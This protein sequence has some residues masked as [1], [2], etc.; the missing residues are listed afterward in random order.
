MLGRKQRL[1]SLAINFDYTAPSKNQLLPY[2]PQAKTCCVD[3]DLR[4][5]QTAYKVPTCLVEKHTELY[6]HRDG[7]YNA[8]SS[9]Y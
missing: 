2:K 9:H 3:G 4:G 5:H 6:Q 8:M 7:L 1:A